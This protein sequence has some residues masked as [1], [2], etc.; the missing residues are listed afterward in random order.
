[1]LHLR[2]P[3][4]Y[5]FLHGQVRRSICL[6]TGKARKALGQITV[7]KTAQQ[8]LAFTTHVSH[9]ICEPIIWTSCGWLLSELQKRVDLQFTHTLHSNESG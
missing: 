8:E 7:G 4:Q 6:M 5:Q 1:M 3:A 9:V 2:L